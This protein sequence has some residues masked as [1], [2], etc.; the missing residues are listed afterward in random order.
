MERNVGLGL[1]L[2]LLKTEKILA[3]FGN[4]VFDFVSYIQK[5]SQIFEE[6]PFNFLILETLVGY[7]F[8]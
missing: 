7:S 8:L 1:A 3:T 4:F 5:V 6:G 2:K